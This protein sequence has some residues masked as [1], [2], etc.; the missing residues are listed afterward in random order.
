MKKLLSTTLAIAFGVSA[1]WGLT[2]CDKHTH[3]FGDWI[4]EAGVETCV[5]S[6]LKRECIDCSHVEERVAT[7]EDHDFVNYSDRIVHQEKCA[8]CEEAKAEGLHEDNG[9]GNCKKCG[10]Y[11]ATDCVEYEI[12]ADGTYAIVTGYDE[13][14]TNVVIV[15]DVYEG[16]PVTEIAPSAFEGCED[17]ER[18]MLHETIT[19]VGERAF[20]GCSSLMGVLLNDSVVNVGEKAFGE[21]NPVIRIYCEMESKPAGW[22]ENWA[23]HR[24]QV[25]WGYQGEHMVNVSAQAIHISDGM[26]VIEGDPAR[27]QIVANPDVGDVEAPEGFFDIFRYDAQTEGDRAWGYGKSA[28]WKYNMDQTDLTPYQEIW[29]AVKMIN[30][31]WNIVGDQSKN[32]GDGAWVYFH[33]TQVGK[34]EFGD[35]LWD[36][37]MSV[38]G[39]THVVEKNQNGKRLEKDAEPNCLARL[40]WDQGFS[41][42]TS[43][44]GDGNAF[45]IYGLTETDI[46]FYCTEVVGLRKWSN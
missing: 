1:V 11:V 29:F 42:A 37:E 2:A 46:S 35:V 19:T 38:G 17:L 31:T 18:V 33:I 44:G 3:N 39:Y 5:G 16:L 27:K 10:A 43:A 22:A 12:S 34:D 8:Y 24:T 4:H 14:E 26:L 25:V 36:I 6:T 30:A 40:L 13:D 7:A 45:L 20:Y 28:L 41:S 9:S 15:S 21:I 23:S 32:V